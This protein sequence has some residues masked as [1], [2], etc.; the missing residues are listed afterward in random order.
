[1][2]ALAGGSDEFSPENGHRLAE[3]FDA[4]TGQS[5][6]H[7]PASSGCL[8]AHQLVLTESLRPVRAK[9]AVS[10]A[11]HGVFRNPGRGAKETGHGVEPGRVRSAGDNDAAGRHRG[12]E[13]HVG[14]QASHHLLTGDLD[15][16]VNA[17][18]PD[19]DRLDSQRLNQVRGRVGGGRW[20][21]GKVQLD[22]VTTLVSRQQTADRPKA[23]LLAGREVSS[24]PEDVALASVAWPQRSTSSVEVNQR[25]WNSSPSR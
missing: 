21:R 20:F 19:V 9:A 6:T 1:M 11:G 23:S 17:V 25:R 15:D 7:D 14:L 16:E 12:D 13:A 5:Y 24:A 10:R 8:V 22:P 2:P 18:A 4:I 3:N